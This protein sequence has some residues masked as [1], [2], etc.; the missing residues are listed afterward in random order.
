V[1]VL[2]LAGPGRQRL[3]WIYLTVLAVHPWALLA[4]A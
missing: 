3:A 2:A 1:P 4:F